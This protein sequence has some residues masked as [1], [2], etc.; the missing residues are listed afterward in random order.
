[1]TAPTR[2]WC[3][4]TPWGDKESSSAADWEGGAWARLLK[5][6]AM[7]RE[8]YEKLGYR[9]VQIEVREVDGE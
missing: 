1:M 8:Q 9:A 6:D 5:Q 2:W 7:R 3:I 4:R